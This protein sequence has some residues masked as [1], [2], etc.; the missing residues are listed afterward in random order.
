MFVS[1]GGTSVTALLGRNF[2]VTQRKSLEIHTCSITIR[3][4]LLS[5]DIVES[6]VPIGSII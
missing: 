6:Q 1:F 4:T 5:L 3:S 2:Y